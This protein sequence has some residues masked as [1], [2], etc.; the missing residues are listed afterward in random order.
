MAPI[1]A[2]NIIEV[3]KQEMYAISCNLRNKTESYIINGEVYNLSSH[4]KCCDT[5]RDK[6][7]D[8]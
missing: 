3:L 1:E 4:K 6:C 2:F 5:W 8:K 7:H